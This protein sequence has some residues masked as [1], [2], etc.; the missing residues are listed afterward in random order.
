MKIVAGAIA[1]TSVLMGS[2][3]AQSSDVR[4]V[5]AAPPGATGYYADLEAARA[6]LQSRNWA[7]AAPLYERL[8]VAYPFDAETWLGLA[9]AKRQLNRPS[10]AIAA[11]EHVIALAGPGYN[12]ALFRIAQQQAAAGDSEAALDA[13]DRY[14]R[15]NAALDRPGLPEMT[16]FASIK[17][18]PRMA[19]LAGR[20]DFSSA[21]RETGWRADLDYLV[22][23]IHR[24]APPYR[25]RDLPPAAT[26]SS[27]DL[28]DHAGERS[29]P[30]MYAGMARL[31]GSLNMNHTQL[32]GLSLD[33]GAPP[34][35]PSLT[36]MPILSYVFADGL[37]V[38]AA[39]DAHHDLVGAEIIS[40]DGVTA[41]NVLTRVRAATSA[42]SD[43]EALWN[44]PL[45][46]EDMAL[47]NGLGVLERPDRASVR[48]RLR[49]GRSITRML[50]SG[51]APLIG[52]LPPPPDVAATTYFMHWEESHWLET[53]SDSSTVYAQV[54]QIAP[55]RD[56]T[57]AAFG[58]RLREALTQAQ[59]R[60]LVIDLRRDNG[61][62]TFTYVELLRTAVA[63]S[64]A[65]PDHRLYVL[66]GRN[67]YSAAA[68]LATDL[69]RLANPIFVGE[70]T[71]ATGNQEGDEGAFHLPYSGLNGTIAGVRWQ[72]SSP[73]DERR[74]I[75]PEAPVQMRAAD[76]F[77]G[78]DPVLDDVRS[79]IA[80][81]R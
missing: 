15:D 16:A 70:P 52:K 56:E 44:A 20:M 66:I 57:L 58:L 51:E 4:G 1:L 32:W 19:P 75:A 45:R 26:A 3:A 7:A 50:T 8:T 13:L 80:A 47:L 36:Y 28:Y 64:A 72:L 23:E 33:G 76:Y 59:A 69:E 18:N 12:R 27:R 6:A 2:A 55:D 37:F 39:D 22:A 34:T 48:L 68:N 53:W 54:N 77:A 73:W 38:V 65:S 24:L 67:T 9:T 60:N 62:D 21:S 63:F 71:G 49:N 74:Y 25:G 46:I 78:R 17:E 30:Q 5:L 29:D 79:M 14:V 11:Y 43:M 81:R 10:E 41:A 40:I 31:L 61:G 42:G 35:H